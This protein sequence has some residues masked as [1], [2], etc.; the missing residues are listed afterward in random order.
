[1]YIK[2]RK[3]VKTQVSVRILGARFNSCT[4]EFI[5]YIDRRPEGLDY[6]LREKLLKE[7]NMMAK[8]AKLKPG[9]ALHLFYKEN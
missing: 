7:V 8:K 5:I 9:W 2:V 1:M 3:T 4:N 6:F